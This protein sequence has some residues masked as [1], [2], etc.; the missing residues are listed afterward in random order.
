MTTGS[1]RN[2]FLQDKTESVS[3]HCIFFGL[4][5]SLRDRVF[6]EHAKGL[7][8]KRK[9]KIKIRARDVTEWAQCLPRLHKAVLNTCRAMCG[10]MEP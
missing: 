10:G 8:T 2:T 9:I 3:F 4:G 6:A 7:R 1:M 5:M